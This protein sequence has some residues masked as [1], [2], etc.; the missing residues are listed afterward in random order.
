VAFVGALLLV[1]VLLVRPQEF[2]PALHHFGL[3]NAIVALAALG[4]VTEL[5]LGRQRVPW[6]PQLPWLLGFVV[7]CFL[8]TVRRLGRE[9]LEIAW[10][11]VGL[12]AI[13]MLVV[14]FAACTAGRWRG[15]A[16]AIVV[17]GTFIAGTCI[18][19]G[20]RPPECIVIDTS[21][22][23]AERSGEGVPDGRPCDNAYVC[24]RGGK[25]RAVYAC[26]SVG[27]FGT[28]TE[29]R[30]VRWRGTLGDPN[31]LALELGATTPLCFA[32]AA[33]RKRKWVTT[34]L[35]V[36]ALA[37][38]LWCVV[39]TRSRGGQVVVLT[40][41]GAYFVRRYGWKGLVASAVFALPVILLGG[42]GG[43]EA[44]SS[45][46]E[47]IDLLYEGMDLIRNYPVLG[48]GAGQFIDHTFNGLTAHNSYVLA[49]AELGLPGSLL[50]TMLVYTSIKIPWVV[51]SRPPPGIDPDLVPF[52]RALVVSFAGILAGIFFLSFCYK[53]VLFVFFG[54][55][56]AMYGAVKRACPS[57]E[58]RISPKELLQ[59][60]A[61]DAVML[62]FVLFYS[63]MMQSHLS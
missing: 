53:A 11:F 17:I 34:A 47:R 55:A 26:E 2:V 14:A 5:A 43:E 1:F 18:H 20:S 32:F 28:F 23:A 21:S 41:L 24:E 19:Q 31:E 29:G 48:V 7:W 10:E 38:G 13:F 8:V 33:T 58:I 6:T 27:L 51:A 40:V 16:G 30:R 9:G 22:Q 50:W 49:A 39:L 59:V 36:A 4:I 60:A 63:H 45:S 3:L 62:V 44:E 25:D 15:L 52:A 54:L 46:L 12:S 42:R 61:M 37:I 56:G 57:F 35:S